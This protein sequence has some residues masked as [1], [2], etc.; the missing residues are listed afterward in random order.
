MPA[1]RFRRHA[2]TILVVA[3]ALAAPALL[4]GSSVAASPSVGPAVAARKPLPRL[5]P[6]GSDALT[7][8]LRTG[9]ITP[10]HYELERAASLFDLDGVR[11]R[12]GDVRRPDPRSATM[13]LRD[14]AIRESG[15]SGGALRRARA[16]LARPTDGGNDGFGAPKYGSVAE[17][18]PLCDPNVCIHYVMSGK[19]AVKPRDGDSSGVPDYVETVLSV[20]Q[21][22]WQTEVG[23]LGYRQPKSDLTSNHTGGNGKLDVYLANVGPKGIYGYCTSDDPHTR[24]GYRYFDLSAYCVLDNDYSKAE[25]GYS[26]PT[27]PLDVTAAHEFFH[28]VQF[29]YDAYEDTYFMEG[30]AVWMEDEVYDGIND[31]LQYLR[32]SP[33]VRPLIP[34]DKNTTYGVYGSWIWW[35]FLT[36]YFGTKAAADPTI[37]KD[38]WKRADGS[39]V[40]PDMYSTQAT[41]AAIAKRKIGGIGWRFA[42]AFADFAAWNT[43]PKHYYEEGGRY[44]S[45]TFTKSAT[46]SAGTPKVVQSATLDHLTNRYVSLKRGAGVKRTARLKV[47]VT[48]PGSKTSPEATVVL[49]KNGGAVSFKAVALNADGDGTLSVDFGST[50]V[51]AIVIVTN[52]S[53]RF[54]ACYTDYPAATYSCAGVPLDENLKFAFTAR[55]VQ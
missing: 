18:T 41:A 44:P 11:A 30:T 22:V 40:G 15:L 20:M 55:L 4:P 16:L 42:W 46:I 48:G 50:I 34:L 51:K 9:A 37:I 25:F 28:A 10:A 49:I 24:S 13:I 38:T 21:H 29:A 39:P 33:I 5:A 2:L 26:D 7:R 47:A 23:D 19:H 1:L 36:E 14:L 45:A 8:A 12:Y 35:R 43:A 27:L 17:E 32:D 3:A 6:A 54:T 31:N 53:T 52:G